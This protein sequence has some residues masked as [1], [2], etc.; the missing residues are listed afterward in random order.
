M[1][2]P[3]QEERLLDVNPQ[4]ALPR[5]VHKP[6]RRGVAVAVADEEGTAFLRDRYTFRL[7]TRPELFEDWLRDLVDD[8]RA[9][10][11]EAAGL[12]DWDCHTCRTAVMTPSLT[13]RCPRCGA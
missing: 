10:L 3:M 1:L 12:Y 2:T 7:R 13:D 9:A 8:G 5:G 11:A 6:R 4:E